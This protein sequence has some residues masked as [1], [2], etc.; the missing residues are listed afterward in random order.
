MSSENERIGADISA[1][2]SMGAIDGDGEEA[3]GEESLAGQDEGEGADAEGQAGE[4][5]APQ[6]EGAEAG[7]QNA[8]DPRI[9]QLEQKIAE[10]NALILKL[11]GSKEEKKVAKAPEDEIPEANLDEL[12]SDEDYQKAMESPAEFRKAMRNVAVSASNAAVKQVFRALPQIVN[13]NVSRNIALNTA[14]QDM[15]R[16]NRDLVPHRKFLAY[17]FD[18]IQSENPEISPI[19]IISTKLPA[20][21]RGKL[22]LKPQQNRQP[23][24]DVK[25]TFVAPAGSGRPAV[26]AKKLSTIG[27]EIAAMEKL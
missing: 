26:A 2:L 18:E 23:V 9:D 11:L 7:E 10:Q 5:G 17:G 6:G 22:N 16:A 27:E 25:K 15:L 3:A 19:D 21:A 4:N 14:I 8:G 12:V 24:K 1:M 13:G 20:W